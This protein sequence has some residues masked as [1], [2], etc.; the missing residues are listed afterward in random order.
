MKMIAENILLKSNFGL[1]RD[2]GFTLM[3]SK[4]TKRKRL[5]SKF[6]KTLV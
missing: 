6:S 4:W 5:S 3:A 1:Y 2:D